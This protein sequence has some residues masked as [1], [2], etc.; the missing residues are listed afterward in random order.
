[1]ILSTFSSFSSFENGHDLKRM[2]V[3]HNN[4][5]HYYM[6]IHMGNKEIEPSKTSVSDGL[7]FNGW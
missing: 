6:V 5:K 1:M 2:Q 4:I 3:L 7:S